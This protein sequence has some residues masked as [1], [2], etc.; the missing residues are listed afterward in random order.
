[1]RETRVRIA[2]GI[3]EWDSSLCCVQTHTDHEPINYFFIRLTLFH[4]KKYVHLAIKLVH[5]HFTLNNLKETI[6]I[7]I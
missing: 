3:V 5:R 6:I 4:K 7:I 2:Q 1:M